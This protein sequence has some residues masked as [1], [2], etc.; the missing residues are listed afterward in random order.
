MYEKPQSKT[1]I[2]VNT[3]L[4]ILNRGR[5]VSPGMTIA[6]TSTEVTASAEATGDLTGWSTLQFKAFS[7][8][9]FPLTFPGN[10]AP[11]T[12]LSLS[13]KT[14]S[15]ISFTQQ[16]VVDVADVLLA[17]Q[18]LFLLLLCFCTES[19]AAVICWLLCW[20]KHKLLH[21]QY[22]GLEQSP[23]FKPKFLV[24]TSS[25]LGICPCSLKRAVLSAVSLTSKQSDF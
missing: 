1:R 6:C 8:K 7:K 19:L 22:K 15:S 3:H 11:E 16:I 5:S 13:R 25:L 12:L 24:P 18:E 4:R 10:Y 17:S 20:E 9:K 14:N 23:N 21:I 2:K